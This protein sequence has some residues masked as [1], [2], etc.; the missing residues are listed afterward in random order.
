MF[1]SP[2]GVSGGSLKDAGGESF[3]AAVK[4]ISDK[5]SL[6]VGEGKPKQN[7]R[8]YLHQAIECGQVV[9][10]LHWNVAISLSL[11]IILQLP[12]KWDHLLVTTPCHRATTSFA[13]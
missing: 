1:F 3:L 9:M 6:S 10:Q 2:H 11:S 7:R 13:Y 4:E 5:Q 8:F 12:T